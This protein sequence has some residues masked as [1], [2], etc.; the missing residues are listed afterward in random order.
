MYTLLTNLPTYFGTILHFSLKKNGV[1]SAVPYIILAAGFPCFGYI[2][3]QLRK[4]KIL[5]TTH[6]RKIFHF[7][8]QLL[9]AGFL[10]AAGYSG[11]D[12]ALAVAMLALAVGTSALA[13][14]GYQ[15][16]HIDIS[17]THAGIIMGLSNMLATVGGK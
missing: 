17:P 2:A 5:S 8:G 10:I 7:L 11:C 12:V 16:N 4:R 13:A 14:S 9:P 1:L 15:V 6:V 3:E